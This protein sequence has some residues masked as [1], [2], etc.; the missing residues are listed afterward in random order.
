MKV[1]FTTLREPSHLLAITPFISAFQRGGHEVAVAAPPDFGERVTATGA[2]FFAF[3]HPGE[4]GLKG[5]WARMRG[6]STE[7]LKQ[8][9]WGELFAGLCAGAAIPG[10]I[11]TIERWKPSLVASESHEFAGHVAA[12]KVGV[13]HIRVAICAEAAEHE[14][15]S[16][17]A[18]YVDAHRRSWGLPPD[19]DGEQIRKE[20][21]VTLFPP[22]FDAKDPAG[23]PVLH[24][25]VA[26]REAAPLPDWWNGSNAPFVYMTLG[27]VAGRFEAI[28]ATYRA[29]LDAIADQPVRALLTVGSNLPLEALGDVPANV[30]VARFVPQDDVI[31]HAAAVLC[32]GGS[33]TVLSVLA[34]GVPM[35]IVPQ[36]AD[37][38][39]NAE[40]VAALG[41][42]IA[43]PLVN[44][45]R[46]ALGEAVS[47]VV[48]EASFRT[49]ARAIAD[50]IRALPLVDEVGSALEER[51]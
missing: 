29:M 34:A 2:T 47:R 42:G 40:R 41:S 46:E 21:A 6:M 1:L 19:P 4:E 39:Y 9:A 25:R 30:H 49:A 50:E 14:I 23:S 48:R 51:E 33:G 43:L 12:A 13:R 10:L 7:E 17:A 18:P 28:H 22:S 15:R 20:G 44:V 11:E 32:H 5:T 45:G 36:F 8:I 24:F 37:Q 16:C 3:G 31:P 38:P 26:Q 27:T 35:V